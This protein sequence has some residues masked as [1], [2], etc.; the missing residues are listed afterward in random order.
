VGRLV[1]SLYRQATDQNFAWSDSICTGLQLANFWQDVARDS[2]IGRVYLPREDRLRF[3][4]T[5]ENLSARQ[6]T[7]AFLELMEFETQRAR[8]LLNA[9]RQIPATGPTALPWRLQLATELFAAGGLA[10]LDRIAAI[11]YRVWE[12]RPKLHKRDMI[13]LSAKVCG[14]SIQRRWWPGRT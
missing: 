7:P 5:D 14:R 11:G 9:W 3:G 6:T 12:T 10:I 8:E 2:D 1:L 4:Y 13:W